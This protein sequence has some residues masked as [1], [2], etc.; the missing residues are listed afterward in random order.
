MKESRTLFGAAMAVGGGL[1]FASAVFLI[2]LVLGLSAWLS[3]VLMTAGFAA[4]AWYGLRLAR[5]AKLG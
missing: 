4:G 1:L 3:A 2:G 5:R